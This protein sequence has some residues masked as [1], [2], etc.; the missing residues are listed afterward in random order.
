MVAEPVELAQEF[1]KF[2]AS[3]PRVS[4]LKPETRNLKPSS[5]REGMWILESTLPITECPV[6]KILLD[7]PLSACLP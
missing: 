3:P 5:F 2:I 4:S 7:S 6:N 1:R